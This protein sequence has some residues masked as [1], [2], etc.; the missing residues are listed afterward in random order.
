[1]SLGG[2]GLGRGKDHGAADYATGYLASQST[3]SISL[4][5]K[6][7]PGPGAGR[8]PELSY[9]HLRYFHPLYPPSIPYS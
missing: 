3:T 9:N 5:Y 2:V 4:G 7:R 8:L 6:W 1:M